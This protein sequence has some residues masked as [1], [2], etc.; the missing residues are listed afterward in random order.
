MKKYSDK[1]V[2]LMVDYTQHVHD[3][4]ISVQEKSEKVAA[5]DSQGNL[6]LVTELLDATPFN[7]GLM[8]AKATWLMKM[9]KST[10]D[11]YM[12]EAQELLEAAIEMDHTNPLPKIH[13]AKF[14]KLTLPA[15]KYWTEQQ[16]KYVDDLIYTAMDDLD[17]LRNMINELHYIN[18]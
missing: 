14:L 3:T 1:I 13:L 2:N 4:I 7:P 6:D 16:I 15:E 17:V 5:D 11:P 10:T 18:Y 12:Q 9:S 8:I